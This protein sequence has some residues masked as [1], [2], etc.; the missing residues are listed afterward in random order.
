MQNRSEPNAEA[1]AGGDGPSAT[2]ARTR[3]LLVDDHS[4]LRQGLGAMINEEPDLEV[5]GEADSVQGALRAAEEGRPDVALV[6]LSLRGGGD[7]LELIKEMRERHP[8]VLVLVLSM[9]D[10]TVYAERALRAGA[11]GYIMKVE[12]AEKVMTAIRQ[13]LGGE[14]YVSPNVAANLLGRMAGGGRGGASAGP[15]IERLS[16]REL[17]VLRC[18]GRGMSGREIAEELFISVKTVEAH[19]E[20]IKQKLD[21]SGSS[22]LLRYA[23][24]HTRVES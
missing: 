18:I 2:G 3:V 14:V 13:V 24:E 5:C 12:A 10:E 9:Y 6:D 4:V 17:Q 22:E 23:I 16:D 7:G 15:S 11:R 20:H 1:R 19:R 21:L 8:E